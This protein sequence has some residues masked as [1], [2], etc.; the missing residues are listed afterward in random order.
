[1]RSMGSLI[2]TFGRAARN[3][4]GR[5]ILYA[6][7]MTRSMHAAMDETSRR[8]EKQAAYNEA[9]GITPVSIRKNL[10]NVLDSLYTV[11]KGTHAK[12]GD[13]AHEAAATADPDRF[14]EPKDLAREIKRLEREMREAAKELEFERAASLRD[15][16]KPLRERLLEL[17]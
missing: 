6:D 9:H 17:G 7:K 10:D 2:Q 1:M 4:A 11:S 8:R 12:R 3:V 13:A 5:V 16:I 14:V 15:R